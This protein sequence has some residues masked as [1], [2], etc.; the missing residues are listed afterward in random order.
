[1][2]IGV[3]PKEY[4]TIARKQLEDEDIVFELLTPNEYEAN[5]EPY[6]RF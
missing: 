3:G 1:M 2:E 4:L 5:D 6:L